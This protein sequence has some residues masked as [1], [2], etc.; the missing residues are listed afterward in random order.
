MLASRLL[1]NPVHS[2][3]SVMTLQTPTKG[4]QHSGTDTHPVALYLLFVTL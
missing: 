1:I 2:V 4:S 3:P